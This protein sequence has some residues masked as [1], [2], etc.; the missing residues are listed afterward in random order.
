MYTVGSWRERDEYSKFGMSGH[1]RHRQT[2]S[3]IW[4]PLER[5]C[6]EAESDERRRSSTNASEVANLT[7]MRFFPLVFLWCSHSDQK[8][9]FPR[10]LEKGRRCTTESTRQVR[11]GRQ[12]LF[13]LAVAFGLVKASTQS[14][15]KIGAVTVA[16]FPSLSAYNLKSDRV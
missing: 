9:H 5:C 6:R 8:V 16:I 2:R 14:I 1:E 13:D 12:V 3:K 7:T 15:V 11:R 10:C 4:L